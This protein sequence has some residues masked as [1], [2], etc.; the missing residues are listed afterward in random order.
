M[1]YGLSADAPMKTKGPN[2]PLLMDPSLPDSENKG[3]LLNAE[4]SDVGAGGLGYGGLWRRCR[5]GEPW[6]QPPK[7]Q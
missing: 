5:S 6:N 1:R 7:R 4:I 2:Q 3:G